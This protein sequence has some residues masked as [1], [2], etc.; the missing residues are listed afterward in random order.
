MMNLFQG[1]NLNV[2]AEE[3]D[4]TVK[5]GMSSCYVFE[6][7]ENNL[8]CVPPDK[9]PVPTV[10]GGTYP[11]VNVRESK[12]SKITQKLIHEEFYTKRKDRQIQ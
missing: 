7:T 3:D 10:P 8:T 5:I 1:E 9:Q 11:E 4:V 2:A 6:L 12:L